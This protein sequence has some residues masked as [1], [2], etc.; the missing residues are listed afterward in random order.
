MKR[1]VTWR[2]LDTVGLEYAEI[3]L[4]PLSIEGSVVLVEG[5]TSHAV[6]Y[7]IALDGQAKTRDVSISLQ[8]DG[9]RS[10]IRLARDGNDRWTVDGARAPRLDGL[11]DVDLSITPSTNTPPLR[12]LRLAVGQSVEVTAAWV[13][14]PTLEVTPLRQTYRRIGAERYLYEAP[15]LAFVA[16]LECDVDGVVRR[17]GDLW[18]R[19]PA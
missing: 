9:T 6:S 15:D 12:R 11:A 17:Y 2:R 8:R 5:R 14:F 10:E 7:R 16:E 4:E 19:I 18:T 1:V 13:R 3:E